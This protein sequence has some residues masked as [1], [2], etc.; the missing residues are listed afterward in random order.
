MASLLDFLINISSHKLFTWADIR[1]NSYSLD[2]VNSKYIN[3]VITDKC[4]LSC[5]GCRG[6]VD[7][8]QQY[9][10]PTMAYDTFTKTVDDCVEAG[11]CYFDLTPV[12]GEIL[13][14]KDIHKYLN[15]LE[16][17]QGVKGYLVTTN[18]TVNNIP[19][20]HKKLNLSLSLYGSG[21]RSFKTF[22]NKDLFKKCIDTFSSLID[23]D[24]PIEITLRNEDL[25]D[26]NLP[27][28]K[29]MYKLLTKKNVAVHDGR[30]NDNRGGCVETDTIS[31]NRRGICPCGVGSGGAIRSDG[32]YYYCAFNDLNK[33]SYVGDLKESSLKKLRSND[34]WN[35]V[36]NNHVNS[37]YIDICKTC[38]AQW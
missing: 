26:I 31:V 24:I 15:Y 5:V 3:I 7:N 27:F 17:H 38:T 37:N 8:V 19:K 10:L 12:I 36:V 32:N 28:R 34:I 22:T 30:V 9:E 25:T 23:I 33:Q 13:L 16:Q 21:S 20:D 14:V 4:N 6:S 1:K 29:V 18:G 11:V 35:D 2:A